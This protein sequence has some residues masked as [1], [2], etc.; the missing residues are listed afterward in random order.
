[1]PPPCTTSTTCSRRSCARPPSSRA[2]WPDRGEP[3]AMALDIR[4]AAEQATGLV[5]KVL[6]AAA[7]SAVETRARPPGRGGRPR[8]VAARAR[9]RS[10]DRADH[11]GATRDARATTLVERD[12]L[13]H[14][15]LNLAANARDAMPDG[16][17]ALRR[18][19]QRAARR[20][21]RHLHARRGGGRVRVAQLHRYGRRNAARG[22]R[23]P[24]R[25]LLRDE[26]GGQ[27]RRFGPGRGVSL[28][29]AQ[30]RLHR[31]A[32]RA[33]TGDHGHRLP[34]PRVARLARKH[35]P[36]RDEHWKREE[37]GPP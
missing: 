30:R 14:V 8:R 17:Q 10:T 1:M 26:A 13:D 33:G 19:G 29:E 34:A 20:R 23:A 3:S 31:R 11:R 32:Q 27:R 24:L 35:A 28:R 6:V 12:Q 21:R 18:D 2:T 9:P 25:A 22:A 5:R 15:L 4:M 7:P 37:E 16:R 36:V